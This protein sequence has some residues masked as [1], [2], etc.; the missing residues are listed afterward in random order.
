MQALP[1]TKRS[2]MTAI[3]FAEA[4]EW[5]TARQMMPVSPRKNKLDWLQNMWLA[6]TFAEAGLHDDALEFIETRRQKNHGIR[7]FLQAVGLH[8]VPVTYGV[9]TV[10][11]VS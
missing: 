9:L 2:W 3:T 5:E 1:E 11:T 7:D 8:E 4:G 6:V 10:E